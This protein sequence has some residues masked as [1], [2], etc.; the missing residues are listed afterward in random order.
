MRGLTVLGLLAWFCQS[1][2]ADEF[3]LEWNA[4]Y[5][6]DVP[7][8]VELETGKIGTGNFVVLADGVRLPT[9]MFDGR[10]PGTSVLRF[11]PPAGT[12]RLV[13]RSLPKSGLA[14]DSSIIDNLF[15][16]ALDSANQSRWVLPK[17]V[18][19]RIENDGLCFSAD[20]TAEQKAYLAYSVPVPKGL[21][22]KP[23]KLEVD[24]SNRSRLAWGGMLYVQQLDSDG[25]ALPEALTD[26]RWTSHM[27]PAGKLVRYRESGRI[28]P[29]AATLQ[30]RIELRR[31]RVRF[32]DHGLP[33][34]DVSLTFPK[35]S[36]SR[37]AVRAA[38]TLPF[39]KYDDAFFGAGSSGAVDDFSFRLGGAEQKAFWYQTRTRAA[40]SQHY[41][42][43]NERELA[44]PSGAGTVEAWFRPDWSALKSLQKE[45]GADVR[46]VTLFDAWQGFR[47]VEGIKADRTMLRLDYDPTQRRF[48]LQI[49][50][51]KDKH[52]ASDW[53]EQI[54]L[55][56]GMWTHVAV[57][58]EPG[59]KAELF[60][61]GRKK[62][63]LAIPEW[64]AAPIAD[65]S[66]PIVNDL[67]AM[68]LFFG[69]RGET[70][71]LWRAPGR[72]DPFFEGE[73]DALRVS[74]GRRY[75]G[76]FTPEVR[77]R[78][79]ESTCSLFDFDRTFDGRCGG[80]GF[81][82]GCVRALKDRVDHR[83][84]F[85]DGRS[86]RYY[87]EEIADNNNPFKVLDPLNYPVIAS[88]SD[89]RASRM[90]RQKSV[91][92]R[93]GEKFAVECPAESVP[94]FVE[95]SNKDGKS[96]VQY[97]I[98]VNCGR[99]D[100]R[101]FGDLADSMRGQGLS[102]REKANKVFQYAISS[103]DYFMNHQVYFCPGSDNP[104]SACNEPMVMLNSY[105]G[106]ECG[107]LNNLAAN[108][109][110]M[111]ADCPASAVR[112]YAHAFQEVFF[113]GRNHIYD[114][115]WQRFFPAMDNETSAGLSEME[116]QP[117]IFNRIKMSADHFIRKGTRGH[118]VHDPAYVEKRAMTLNPGETFRLTYANDGQMNNLQSQRI[119]GRWGTKAIPRDS[120][121]YT[122]IAG[123]KASDRWVLRVDRIFPHY[124]TG[125][126]LFDGVPSPD[127]PAFS[128]LGKD[129]F[130]YRMRSCY[131][132]VW[133]QYAA[134]AADGE[135][136]PLDVSTDNGRTWRALP[137]GKDG[138][139]SIEYMVKARHDYLV[140]V[141]APIQS[142]RRFAARTEVEVNSRTY[143]GFL[144]P[145]RNELT[146]KA[147]SPESVRVTL[148]WREKGKEIV[149]EG[150]MSSGTM[151]GF[152][153]S[154]VLLDPAVAMEIPVKGVSPAAK[155]RTYGRV[156]AGLENGLLTISYNS[157]ESA[158]F[159]HGDD[160]P[161]SVSEFPAFAAVDVVDG[162][163]VKTLTVIVSPGALMLKAA[164]ATLSGKAA[165]AMADDD[166]VHARVLFR[167]RG[168]RASFACPKLPGGRY[169][170]LALARF[171][172]HDKSVRLC[173]VDPLNPKKSYRIARDENAMVDYLDACYGQKGGRSRWKWDCAGYGDE[174][175]QGAKSWSIRRWE[176]PDGLDHIDFISERNEGILAELAGVLV[177]PEPDNEALC[178]ITKVLFGL[179][180]DPF[181]IWGTRKDL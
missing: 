58:W 121:D 25:E 43:R 67:W 160:L 124:S 78:F 179:N 22:G 64:Q 82:P 149:F 32:D 72:Q 49:R 127:N 62:A 93:P 95:I 10:A 122:Q 91:L 146:Y 147:A 145:G 106:F 38:A 109:F 73:G 3:P 104:Q 30:L 152:E 40:W 130:T 28:H 162:G 85:A 51:Y 134:Y 70:A 153:R 90:P 36:L 34:T 154:L 56:E 114:L 74:F 139:S 89:H 77:P 123:A 44:F 138:V 110:T 168:D 59:A 94:D 9:A 116:D 99:M 86:I 171:A 27:R 33:I 107:P 102:D 180:C 158:A 148:G 26:V 24:V 84:R 144:R 80:Y 52:Y 175:G 6:T 129:A 132:V 156:S 45:K 12:R 18:V 115:S 46:P 120:F 8:E 140:R 177:L 118:G 63:S 113:D 161:K 21:A 16:G 37:L 159:R 2:F 23:A 172:A 105:C 19:A 50:D 88:A 112:G 5:P 143:P 167:N 119:G 101:S 96:P 137:S 7:Y 69:C 47:E 136:V 176:F 169:L 150:A 166:S 174:W 54:E 126:L 163:A 66:I 92:A 60:I 35:L 103:S 13:C 141:N 181:H 53:R 14:C 17:G 57:Q 83:L 98:V 100:P 79:D 170:V 155:A 108:M 75:S 48:A 178:E 61:D 20:A 151:P 128:A 97:P 87:S 111:V 65:K 157:R 165:F 31:L 15:A 41:Q 11:A 71:R 4:T 135:A 29:R 173:L 164:D 1:V 125:V 39:P 68:E 55:P 142:V 81:V 76:D 131:P 117:G 133:A 42:F